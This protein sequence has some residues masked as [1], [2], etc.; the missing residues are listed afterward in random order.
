MAAFGW[1]GSG[2]LVV[3]AQ[4]TPPALELGEDRLAEKLVVSRHVSRLAPI[5][6]T[7]P[8]VC[9]VSPDIDCIYE[10]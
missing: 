6:D 7:L 5:C 3:L 10:V 2:R 9:M 1:I 4:E 8:T